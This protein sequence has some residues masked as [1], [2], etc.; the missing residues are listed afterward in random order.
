MAEQATGPHGSSEET[1]PGQRTV[2]VVDL[3]GEPLAPLRAL[4]EILLCL[5]TWE[6]DDRRDPG[7]GTEPLRL[8]APL[9][10]R[11]ALAAV[12]RLLSALAP[13]QSRGPGPCVAGCSPRTAATSTR[14]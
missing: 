10:G 9:A 11:V 2:L 7:A 8:P 4:E 5:G 6:D 1:P 13:T 12:Q 14:R 3:D